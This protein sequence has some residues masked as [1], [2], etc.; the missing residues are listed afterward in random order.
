MKI[1]KNF[2]ILI[3]FFCMSAGVYYGGAKFHV[4]WYG[5]NDFG[6]YYKMTA[7]PFNNTAKAPWA[8]RVLTPTIAHFVE[9]SGLFYDSKITPYKNH[10]LSHEK[11]IYIAST[12]S[13]LIFTNYIF[14]ALAA[15]FSYKTFTT[16]L[17]NEN[18]RDQVIA[19]GAPSLLFLSFSTVVHGYAGLTEG[20]SIFLVSILCYFL[21]R[22]M[23]FLF[24][25]FSVLSVLQRELVPLILLTYILFSNQLT[26]R[27]K[28]A[29]ISLGT[30]L[31][32]FAIRAVFQ[33][34]GNEHQTQVSS[35]LSNFLT[36]SINKEFFLQAVLG[37]NIPIFVILA[38][39]A[40]GYR[41]IKPFVPFFL[42]CMV[43]ATLGVA[44]GLG[45]N[46]GR[47]LNMATPLLLVGI[48]LAIRQKDT[49]E[50]C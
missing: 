17:G 10:Y 29:A 19:L 36:F 3:S 16:I 40:V 8:Y 27:L 18:F 43:L 9:K 26:N 28:Y 47:I 49:K 31:L 21:I 1:F 41:N 25:V 6:E 37:N 38:A 4:P 34:P 23:P 30:F 7:E 35:F 46:I 32:Y 20:G 50:P 44:T 5:A 12:L 48:A 42:T 13:A 33:I 39:I 11:I 14:F 15:F 22:N 2:I 45:N 24:F